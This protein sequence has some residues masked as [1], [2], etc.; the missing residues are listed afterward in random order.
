VLFDA[1]YALYRS[2]DPADIRRLRDGHLKHHGTKDDPLRRYPGARRCI[3]G[4]RLIEEEVLSG[5]IRTLSAL[6]CSTEEASKKEPPGLDFQD[7]VNESA[8]AI[9]DSMYVYNGRHRFTT[10][11]YRAAKNRLITVLRK[12]S[13][14]ANAGCKV[15]QLKHKVRVLMATERLEF[16]VAVARVI[17]EESLTDVMTERLNNAFAMTHQLQG[18]D[19]DSVSCIDGGGSEEIDLMW[20]AVQNANLTPIE[21]ELIEAHLRG[22]RKF[23]GRMCKTICPETGNLYTRAWLSQIYIRACAKIRECHA[24]PSKVAA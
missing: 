3:A 23:R 17:Q 8:W 21:R 4:L 22:D 16:E 20:W 19:V 15:Q 7:C 13:R 10:F 18:R 5:Y 6:S 14:D 2:D 12:H 24:N 9:W 11:I 1:S